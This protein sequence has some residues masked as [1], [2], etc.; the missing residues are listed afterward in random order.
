VAVEL[1]IKWEG[2]APG[3]EEKRLSLAAFGGPLNLLLAAL[4]RIATNIVTEVFE[5]KARGR[6]ADEAKR[7]DIEIGE[8]V[9]GSSGFDGTITVATVPYDTL[10]LFDLAL[11]AGTQLLEALDAE[12]QGIA[13]ST[14]VRN[15]LRS[16]PI[17]IIRQTYL[18][19]RNGTTVKEVSFGEAELPDLPVD[20][21]HIVEYFGD[22]IGVGFEPGR[23]E[24]KM[25]PEMV[26]AVTLAAT[27][28]QVDSALGLRHTKVRAVT[29][30][31]GNLHRLLILQDAASPL[32]H[33]TREAAIFERWN[34]A[35]ARLAK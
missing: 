11:S 34:G 26:P 5:E 32:N 14:G 4:R 28:D 22:I 18:L 27:S 30:V 13:K 33:S 10:P 21:P 25:K 20:L 2:T 19:H 31:Q 3:L 9:K 29:V 12:R 23:L 7:L 24:V 15:Y 8:L 17:G 1:K 35:L 6:F 16:L